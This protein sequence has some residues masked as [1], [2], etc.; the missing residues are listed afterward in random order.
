MTN[1]PLGAKT[2]ISIGFLWKKPERGAEFPRSVAY[3]PEWMNFLIIDDEPLVAKTLSRLLRPH[4]TQI[5]APSAA[6]VDQVCDGNY[7]LVFCD[8]IMPNLSGQ[9]LYT[10]ACARNPALASQFV[11]ITGGTFSGEL[12]SFLHESKVRVLYKPFD[13]IALRAILA[14]AEAKADSI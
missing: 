12:E 2:K 14:A 8:L 11:F 10:L 5:I 13:R 1:P 7:D 9:E 4:Q 3:P 6:A